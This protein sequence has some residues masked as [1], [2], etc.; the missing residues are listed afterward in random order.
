MKI[1]KIAALSASL[2]AAA[3]MAPVAHGQV[4]TPRPRVAPRALEMFGARGV[5]IGVSIRELD[6]AD[7][8]GA[9]AP[10]SGVFVEDVTADGPAAAAGV[11]KGDVVMEFDGE[12]VRSVSQFTRLVRETPAGRKV[13]AALWRDGQK[14]SVTIQPRASDGFRVFDNFD[15]MPVQPAPLTPPAAPL[16]PAPPALPA[17][18]D[19]EGFVWRTGGTLGMTVSD[20]S[21]QL[22]AYFGTRDGVLV[23]SVLDDSAAAKAGVKAGDVITSIDGSPVGSSSE[24]RRRVQRLENGAEFALEVVRDKKTLTLKGKVEEGRNRRTFRSVL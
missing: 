19:F 2:V 22:A 10:S 6:D 18:P 20:L 23:T 11:K 14:I 17:I 3:A 7:L 16:P 9:K 21:S 12:R 4:T 5:Q 1:F 8:K 15:F 13:A 24:L